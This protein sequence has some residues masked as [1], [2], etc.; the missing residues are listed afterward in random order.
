MSFNRGCI[1]VFIVPDISQIGLPDRPTTYP[2]YTSQLQAVGW[3]VGQSVRQSDG[4]FQFVQAA[5]RWNYLFCVFLHLP[6]INSRLLSLLSPYSLLLSNHSPFSI[7]LV[8]PF[9]LF[10]CG[11]AS[12]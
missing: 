2:P 5:P 8:S 3:I 12:L 9:S 11:N 1:L 10:T 4:D 7:Q 6:L